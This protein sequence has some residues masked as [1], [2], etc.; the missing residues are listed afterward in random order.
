MY[1]AGG[2]RVSDGN[3]IR[4]VREAIAAGDTLDISACQNNDSESS[5]ILSQG[6]SL[7]G[8]TS[9]S[10][11]T[12]GSNFINGHPIPS[13]APTITTGDVEVFQSVFS[14]NQNRKYLRIQNLSYEY[15]LFVRIGTANYIAL[16]PLAAEIWESAVAPV[17]QVFVSGPVQAE[18]FSATEDQSS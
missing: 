2:A 10:S 1:E 17:D 5:A 6:V 4:T 12:Q 18:A 16:D 14:A 7:A 13:G 15:P 11:T 9:V 8:G 3:T